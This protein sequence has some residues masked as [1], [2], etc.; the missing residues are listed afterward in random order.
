MAFKN[1]GDQ[2]DCSS[3]ACST[4]RMMSWLRVSPSAA[5]R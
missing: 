4:A 1:A 3:S 2:A 5:A